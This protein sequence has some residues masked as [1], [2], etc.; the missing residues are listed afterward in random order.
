MHK[1]LRFFL[2]C[3]V[4]ASLSGCSGAKKLTLAPI[5]TFDPDNGNIPAPD[6]KEENQIWDIMDMTFFYQ[7]EKVLDLNWSARKVGKGLGLARGKPADN[8]NA[9]D[10]VPNSSWYTNRHYHDRMSRAE[11]RRGPNTSPGPD[12]SGAWTITAG[13]FEG[14]T[15]GFT[16]KD[17]RGDRYLLKFDPPGFQEM[18]SSAEV[19][20]TKILHACGYFVPQN[21]VVYFDPELLQIGETAKV[22]EGGFKRKMTPA[23]LEALLEP[24]PRRAD[25]KMRTMASKFVNGKPVGVWNYI[26]MRSDDPNDLVYHQHRRELRG[27]R[28]ISSW[29]SD[30]D[31][32][33]AN[34]LA[35]YT[36]DPETGHKYIQHYL[37]DMGSTLGSNNI[38]PHA[39]KYGNEYLIDPRTVGLQFLTLGF[40]V[41]PWEF[42]TGH[43]NP[44][45]S[46]VGYYES[47]IFD[48]DD[49]YP[50]Y[51][52]PAFEYATLRDVF[53]GA[54]I[55]MAFSDEDIRSIVAEAQLTDPRAE[56]YLIKTLI[57]RRDKIG[58]YWFSKMNPLDKFDFARQG[59][60]LKLTFRDLAVDSDLEKE[61]G[62]RYIHTTSYRAGGVHRQ[63]VSGKPEVVISENG[64]GFLDDLIAARGS[65]KERDKI[66]ST[67]IQVE[68]PGRALSKKV[69]VFFY[70]PGF[71]GEPRVVGVV[72][73]E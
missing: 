10:E 62:V 72:R 47:R 25:G 12:Q 17:G 56:A 18:G 23:D 51:P 58:R 61:E 26:G 7:V 19:I 36:T 15:T 44:E 63:S 2:F 30:E 55:V 67:S 70:Y 33:A 13:K 42:E 49:W 65:K 54:K 46:S 4:A 27:L 35:V 45:F 3:V 24:I 16:I 53:W 32:R 73:E 11:L 57:E 66:F 69:D 60:I 29:L 48:P 68:R 52:N 64:T 37:I 40:W 43:L 21:S 34:T 1:V 39:P 31:R 71:S 28:T 5:K 59:T 6:D 9:L 22:A 50:T 20:S 8:V 14:G 38:I 41:K